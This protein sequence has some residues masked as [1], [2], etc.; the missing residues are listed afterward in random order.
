MKRCLLC[1]LLIAL[2][3]GFVACKRVYFRKTMEVNCIKVFTNVYE[4]NINGDLTARE[5]DPGFVGEK[6]VKISVIFHSKAEL[7]SAVLTYWGAGERAGEQTIEKTFNQVLDPPEGGVIRPIFFTLPGSEHY[8]LCEGLYFTFAI[9]YKNSDDEPG[10]FVSQAHLIMSTKR[11]VS[12][13][14]IE[15]ANCPEPPGP[16]E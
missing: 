4:T 5:I 7:V 11:M 8:G 15:Q 3:A 2:V 12:G 9:N 1:L 16:S 13:N 10:L 6:S 14:Q